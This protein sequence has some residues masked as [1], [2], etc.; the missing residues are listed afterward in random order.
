MGVRPCVACVSATARVHACVRV[1]WQGARCPPHP[2]HALACSHPHTDP[3]LGSHRGAV[4]RARPGWPHACASTL[5]WALPWAGREQALAH[6][7]TT[8]SH[9]DPRPASPLQSLA[10][11]QCSRVQV[12]R[13]S[14]LSAALTRQ[15]RT[16][17]SSLPRTQAA[18]TNAQGSQSALSTTSTTRY[19]SSQ[20]SLEPLH[21]APCHLAPLPA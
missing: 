3:A 10:H 1:W 9:S 5:P 4:Q 16:L 15:E 8:H 17:T 18:A 13:P 6:S 11:R 19:P 14:L 2:L 21:P 7:H 20:S 12:C